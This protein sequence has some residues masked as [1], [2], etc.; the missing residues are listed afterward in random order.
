MKNLISGLTMQPISKMSI[1]TAIRMR[2][3]KQVSYGNAPTVVPIL[4]YPKTAFT[5]A[6]SGVMPPSEVFR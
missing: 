5:N 1:W 4:S 3:Q 2:P 6:S